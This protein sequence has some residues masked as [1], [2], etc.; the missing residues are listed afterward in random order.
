MTPPTEPDPRTAPDD[1][2]DAT[3]QGVSAPDP[4]EGGNDAPTGT[5]TRPTG[6]PRVTLAVIVGAHGITGEV[7]LKVLPT[8]CR[9]IARSMTAR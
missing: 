5:A 4:A 8:T 3:N 2:D 1:H 9:T 6:E 7:R